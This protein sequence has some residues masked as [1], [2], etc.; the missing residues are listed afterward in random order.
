MLGA[1]SWQLA[2]RARARIDPTRKLV[3][4]ALSQCLRKL[5]RH[6]RPESAGLQSNLRRRSRRLEECF[7]LGLNQTSCGCNSSATCG[8]YPASG[9]SYSLNFVSSVL[10]ASKQPCPRHCNVVTSA[11]CSHNTTWNTSR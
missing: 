9:K 4:G 11:D 5:G 7:H 10:S 3:A 6:T 1:H 8:A 2:H